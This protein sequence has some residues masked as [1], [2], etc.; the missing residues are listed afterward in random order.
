[1][2]SCCRLLLLFLHHVYVT[3]SRQSTVDTGK[4]SIMCVCVCVVYRKMMVVSEVYTPKITAHSQ[5]MHVQCS[6]SIVNENSSASCV[7]LMFGTIAAIISPSASSSYISQFRII[8]KTLLNCNYVISKR[9][10]QHF[11][12]ESTSL[13]YSH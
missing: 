1:M 9:Y 11:T 2:L 6:T 10:F 7:L 8:I 13:L 5:H 12:C 3:T 4:Q